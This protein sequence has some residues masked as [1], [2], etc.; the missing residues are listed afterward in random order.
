MRDRRVRLLAPA[1]VALFGMIA[2]I[3]SQRSAATL[4]V[5]GLAL[6]AVLAGTTLIR[7]EGWALTAGMLASGALLTVITH[8]QSA[9]VGWFGICALAGVGR[10]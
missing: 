1:A 7:T 9:N 4:M 6:A 8:D 2:V 3:M 5:T 10:T